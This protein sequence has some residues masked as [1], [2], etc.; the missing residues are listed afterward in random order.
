MKKQDIP[1]DKSALDGYSRELYYVKG[2][3]GKFTTGLSSGW[4]VKASA[5]ENEWN[6]IN[7]EIDEAKQKVADGEKSPIYYFMIKNLMDYSL[8]GSYMGFW[9]CKIKKHCKP[10]G[11]SKLKD[12]TLEKY[13]NVFQVA[14]EEIK[15]FRG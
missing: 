8:L 1:Q 7:K 11:F 12:S 14:V 5:L 4:E 9:R 15:S 13:A 3:D 10:K 2:D 6:D